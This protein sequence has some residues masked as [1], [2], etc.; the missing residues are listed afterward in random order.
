[1]VQHP[2]NNR[3]YLSDS[4]CSASGVEVDAISGVNE[5]KMVVDGNGN[6]YIAIR[7]GT[8]TLNYYKV[9]G[10]T[11]SEISLSPNPTLYN[12]GGSDNPKYSYALD[13]EGRL[14]AINNSANDE[15][16]VYNKN[17]ARISNA[18]VYGANSSGNL[19]GYKNRVLSRSGTHV[20]DI[21]QNG[22]NSVANDTLS[23][24]AQQPLTRCTHTDTKGIDGEGTDFIRCA[25]S[26]GGDRFL[27]SLR[28]SGGN[29]LVASKDIPSAINSVDFVAGKALVN[30]NNYPLC[31]TTDAPSISCENTNAPA[32]DRT[33]LRDGNDNKY[34]KSD[35][36]NKV[37]YT[38]GGVVKAGDIFGPP[39]DVLI[40]ASGVSGGSASFDLTKFAYIPGSG[41]CLTLIA[42]LSTV[43][44]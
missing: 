37:L 33:L 16:I 41:S 9:S 28:Y 35:G 5:A 10:N 13:G 3:I 11:A 27:Y 22:T 2:T 29:Y 19:L 25:Y 6:F 39:T 40:P 38:S 42:Y 44:R 26:S 1:L 15:V 31:T 8:T 32:F 17:G 23:Y 7:S 4:E 12:P 21:Y 30:S 18:T 34:L 36:M 20:Y 24:I 43:L 14:Y